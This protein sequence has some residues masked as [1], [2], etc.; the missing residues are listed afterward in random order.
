MSLLESVL[1]ASTMISVS[2]LVVLLTRDYAKA[3]QKATIE[4]S[5][6]SSL[7]TGFV[8]ELDRRLSSVHKA[9]DTLEEEASQ[10]QSSVSSLEDD[11][12][13]LRST[14]AAKSQVQELESENQRISQRIQVVEESVSRFRT[15][16]SISAF[17]PV[18][19]PAGQPFRPKFSKLNATERCILEI[20]K[21]GKKS[22]KE[23]QERTELSREHVSRKLKRLF[24]LG[25]V[26]RDETVRPY[27]YRSL[28]QMQQEN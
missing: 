18:T 5:R 3:K 2:V 20:L 27:E 13:S 14:T 19:T 4:Y 24:D 17:Q 15:V 25:F 1:L 11:L 26:E 7:A 8:A 10:L 22:Y 23:I 21:D 6:A 28:L 9:Y 12:A 16:M